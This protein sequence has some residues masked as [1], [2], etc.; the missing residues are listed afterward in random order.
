[1]VN[2]TF[3][4]MTVTSIRI[5]DAPNGFYLT[6]DTLAPRCRLPQVLLPNQEC[7]VGVGLNPI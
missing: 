7:S 3:Q 2:T 5:V 4:R 6:Y 1:L